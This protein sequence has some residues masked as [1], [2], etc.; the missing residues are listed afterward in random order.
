MI[1]LPLLNDIQAAGLTPMQLRN[2]IATK[3]TEYLPN[4]EVSVIVREVN[5]FKVSVLGEVKKP[6]RYDFKG[7]ATVLEAIATAGGLSDFAARSKITILR[8]ENGTSKRS[9]STTTRSSPRPREATSV[10]DPATSFSSRSWRVLMAH[11]TQTV[12]GQASSG[13]TRAGEIWGRR[14]WLG[15]IVF[16]AVLAI[17]LG[18]VA[19]LPPMFRSRATVLVDREQVPEAF[20]RS[21]VSAEVE[22]RIQRISQEVLSRERLAG[23]IERFNLYPKLPRP[24][25]NESAIEEL[26]RDIV[27][28]PKVVDQGGGRLATVGFGL[29]YRGND[30]VKVAEVTNA[31]AALYV[32]RNSKIRERQASDTAQFLK[33]Q[34]TDMKAKLD[35][36]ERRIG[37]APMPL[38][39]E[40]A[41]LERLNMRLRVN[42]DRQLRAMDRRERLVK[43]AEGPA[44]AATPGMAPETSAARLTKLK[45]ELAELKTRYTD[46]YPDVIRIKG[47]IAA[48]EARAETRG[49]TGAAAAP[50][51]GRTGR[52]GRRRAP[53]AEGRGAHHPAADRGLRA[54]DG[55]RAEAAA[56]VPAS[57]ARLRDDEGVLPVAAQALRRRPDRG[58]HGARPEERAVPHPGCCRASE[59]DPGAEPHAARSAGPRAGGR[60]GRAR[61]DAARAARHLVPHRGRPPR[62]ESRAAD[63]RDPAARHRAGSPRGRRRFGLVTASLVVGLGMAVG[64]SYLVAHKNEQLTRL[65]SGG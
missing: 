43:E 35:E 52:R 34:L 59:G 63:R 15:L 21:A 33:A 2:N 20:V 4:P 65:L 55:G 23:L 48:L 37:Q 3:L 64:G 39:A 62:V 56:G 19:A 51:A 60:R 13:F 58:E 17:S 29:S 1:S 5:H 36:Q 11:D 27:L 26:R 42:S 30:P 31:L 57:G 18:L 12:A 41:G 10:S 9:P 22:T 46:K 53:H 28:E 38:E 40:V 47:E 7:Q 32:E 14:K 24:S 45:Q 8:Q 44:L 25:T 54:P 49:P 6:G 16:V 50:R 61:G